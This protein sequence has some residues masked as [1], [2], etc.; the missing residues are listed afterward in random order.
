LGGGGAGGGAGA[1][2]P[3]EPAPEGGAGTPASNPVSP[4]EAA[5][6]L[7]PLGATIGPAGLGVMPYT[8]TFSG[9][10]FHIADFIRG[11]DSLVKTESSRV[12]V[13]GRLLTIDGFSLSADQSRGFPALGATFEVTTYLTPPEEGVTAAATPTAPA[14][15]AATPASTT[16]GGAP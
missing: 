7:L 14:P 6:S 10:F 1:R 5:A 12:S 13:D 16:T 8:L 2:P 15:A 3:S 11:L 9:S 4:T